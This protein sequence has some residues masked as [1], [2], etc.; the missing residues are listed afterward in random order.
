MRDPRYSDSVWRLPYTFQGFKSTSEPP[1]RGKSNIW[2][3]PKDRPPL[4]ELLSR[5][6]SAPADFA[7][8]GLQVREEANLA[9]PSDWCRGLC[10]WSVW[11]KVALPVIPNAPVGNQ[12]LSKTPGAKPQLICSETTRS[13]GFP[14][15]W[16]LPT[17]YLGSQHE[18]G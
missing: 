18:H 8:P 11:A 6:F 5:R 17:L 10:L 12:I 9:D 1:S 14:K 15:S 3:P 2:N 13:K 16:N 4:S 7:D